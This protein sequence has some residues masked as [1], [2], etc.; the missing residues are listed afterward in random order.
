[1]RK[2]IKLAKR[3]SSNILLKTQLLINKKRLPDTFADFIVLLSLLPNDEQFTLLELKTLAKKYFKRLFNNTTFKG[4]VIKPFDYFFQLLQSNF[5]YKQG[6]IKKI[7]NNQYTV[8]NLQ[9]DI[10]Q[11]CPHLSLFS[12]FINHSVLEQYNFNSSELIKDISFKCIEKLSHKTNY[13]VEFTHKF[14]KHIFGLSKHDFKKRLKKSHAN[15]NY[16]HRTIG[17][18]EAYDLELSQNLFKGKYKFI[19]SFTLY[20]P[21]ISDDSLDL[22]INEKSLYTVLKRL[23]R[24]QFS[25]S[26]K[27][28]Y[29]YYDA[30]V[31]KCKNENWIF[32]KYYERLGY[33][34]Y[35]STN[36]LYR[37]KEY[38]ETV[39]LGIYK[40]AKNIY[41]YLCKHFDDDYSTTPVTFKTSLNS[42]KS[43]FIFQQ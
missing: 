31:A 40:Q 43:T 36:S 38:V 11:N 29:Y 4:K 39:N 27:D 1:M 23:E 34:S 30:S 25:F 8:N 3:L 22:Y 12:V 13:K 24:Q 16:V 10:E 17:N 42:L 41:V 19:T 15:I 7:S 18:K 21:K 9:S 6:L 28:F 14:I 2:N 35:N 37:L 5:Y 26:V 33:T 20:F 32:T